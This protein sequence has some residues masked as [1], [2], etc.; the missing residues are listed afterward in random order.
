VRRTDL[1]PDSNFQAGTLV[2]G[3]G[4]LEARI[5][6]ID[7]DPRGA[8]RRLLLA[9]AVPYSAADTD[10]LVVRLGGSPLFADGFE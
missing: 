6:S 2:N 3:P 1:L 8:R 4:T 5:T 7:I 10:S 9:G